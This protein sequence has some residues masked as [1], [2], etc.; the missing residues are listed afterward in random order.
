MTGTVST[1][2]LRERL[3]VELKADKCYTAAPN[4]GLFPLEDSDC[5][6]AGESAN[7][8]DVIVGYPSFPT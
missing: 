7:A 8:G 2:L 1:A 3:K 6:I 5:K 4:Q